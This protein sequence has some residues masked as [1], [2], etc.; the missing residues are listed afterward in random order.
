MT[1]PVTFSPTS[2]RLA[3][4]L[5]YAGQAQKEVTVNE[6]LTLADLLLHSAI[7]GSIATPPASPTVGQTWLVAA[8]PTG[9]WTGHAGHLAGWSEG[10]WRFIV[11]VAG[12]RVFDKSTGSFRLFDATWHAFSRP[13]APSGGA[14]VDVQARSAISQLVDLLVSAGVI[15]A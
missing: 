12:L 8:S 10:G 3:L 1:E 6:A 5:L 15:S 13:A 4:P 11:P 9:A 7:E 14:V 2:P